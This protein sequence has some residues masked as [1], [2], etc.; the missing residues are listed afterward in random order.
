MNG[1]TKGTRSTTLVKFDRDWNRLQSWTFPKQVIRRFEP[2]SNS[3]GSWGS[4]GRLYCTSSKRREILCLSVPQAESTLR[5]EE[6]IPI[7]SR[8]QGFACDREKTGVIYGINGR[9]DQVVVSR[10]VR[11]RNSE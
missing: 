1:F 10:L 7:S 9:P 2:S 8:G 6:L 11:M 4:D 3:G 5:L